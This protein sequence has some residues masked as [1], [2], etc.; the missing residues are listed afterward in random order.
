MQGYRYLLKNIG[1]LTI[2]QFGTKF[3]V[4]LLVPLYTSVLSTAEYGSYELFTTTINLLVPIVTLNISDAVLLFALDKT[5]EN[6]EVLSV[7]L[8]YAVIGFALSTI[9]LILN[10]IINL[11]PAIN[12]YCFYFPLLF[13]L[14]VINSIFFG[15]ARGIDCVK[16]IAV[17]GIISSTTMIGCN[18]LLLLVF[19]C[20]VHGY[21]VANIIS[22]LFQSVYLYVSC[23]LWNYMR[24]KINEE[25]EE[26]MKNYSIPLIINNVGWWVN[27]S[28]DRYIVT[29]ICGVSINGIYSVGYKIPSILNMF[30]SIFNQ[31]WTMSAVKDFDSDDSKGF[32]SKMYELYNCGMVLVC[33]V[34]VAT[35][36]LLAHVLYAQ[37]FFEAWKYVPFLTMSIVFGALSGFFGGIFAA[38][39]DSKLFGISTM[40]G[41]IVN[42]VLNIVLIYFIGPIGAAVATLVA[43]FLV[44]LI[45]LKHVQKY[46]NIKINLKRDSV[47]YLLLI[48]QS[49]ILFILDDCLFLYFIEFALFFIIISLYSYELRSVANQIVHKFKEYV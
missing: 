33:S 29:W 13:I 39:K 14:T 46:I 11:L 42:V 3:L 4:F 21:F 24:I 12:E 22:L 47:S 36:R 40:I 49:N 28:S 19:K 25:L 31:V 48:I 2:S 20:G 7:G 18:L 43:F 16:E 44:W 41:A 45:R 15:F 5:K 9:F 27:N 8:K 34:I 17:G 1:L 6:S 30:Q 32:F 37:D 26:E 10:S 38:A 35:S 23:K